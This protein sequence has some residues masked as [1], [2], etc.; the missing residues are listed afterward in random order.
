MLEFGVPQSIST[1]KALQWLYQGAGRGFL[2]QC[3][4]QRPGLGARLLTERSMKL[5]VDALAG[6]IVVRHPRLSCRQRAD[7]RES[8]YCTLAMWHTVRFAAR[9]LMLNHKLVKRLFN[10]TGPKGLCAQQNAVDGGSTAPVKKAL[11]SPSTHLHKGSCIWIQRT[12]LAG[13]MPG[14][15]G[16]G[17]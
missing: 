8:L 2:P 6:E 12:Q 11:M 14:M 10:M 1:A 16:R 9:G 4:A 5:L 13:C 3:I 7:M 17:C 15:A